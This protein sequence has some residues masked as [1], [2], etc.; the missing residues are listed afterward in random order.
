MKTPPDAARSIAACLLA[1]SAAGCTV[2]QWDEPITLAVATP[3]AIDVVSFNGNVV[4]TA[5]PRLRE[6]TLHVQREA[7]HGAMRNDEME[8]SLP[9]I[10]YSYELS[11]GDS[12]PTLRVKTWTTHAE[13][14]FQRAHVYITTPAVNDVSVQTQRGDVML[15]ESSG[16][17]N[18]ET[19][20]GRVSLKTNLAMLDAVTIV[21][22]N[23][24]VEYRIRAESTGAFDCRAERGDVT[25]HAPRGHLLVRAQTSDSLVAVFNGGTN[26]VRLHSTD[27]DIEV[28]V[29]ADPVQHH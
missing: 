24:D 9:L 12:G 20:G 6:A 26:P 29:D 21:N 25:L 8:A 19:A 23:G 28:S 1:A 27:G 16:P 15:T 11:P 4:V 3:I 13:P 18:V 5:E 10:Q 14:Y 17:V 22:R 7:T 2:S